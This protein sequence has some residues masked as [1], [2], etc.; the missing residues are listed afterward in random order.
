VFVALL[1]SVSSLFGGKQGLESQIHAR[2]KR[3]KPQRGM[4]V[5]RMM[6]LNSPFSQ[7][8]RFALAI[9]T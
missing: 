4:T 6:G 9:V 1:R 3:F 8:P 5:K 7:Q 2:E